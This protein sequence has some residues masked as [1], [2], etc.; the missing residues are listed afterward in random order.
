MKVLGISGSLIYADNH[1]ASAALVIDGKLVGNYE[2]ERF[3]RIKHSV[4]KSFPINCIQRLLQENNLTID[5]ID[6]ISMPHDP[7]YKER[8]IKDIVNRI[9]ANSTHVPELIYEDHHMAHACDSFFQ[10]GFE[11]A[12][13]VIIDGSGDNKD[14][15]TITHIK[16]NKIKVLKKYPYTKSLG[17]LYSTGATGYTNLGEFGEGKFMGLASYGQP[18]DT[19]PFR[20]ENNDI[21]LDIAYDETAYNLYNVIDAGLV[22]YFKKNSYP[23]AMSTCDNDAM[24]YANFASSIQKTFNDIVMELVRYAKELSGEDNLVLSGGCIQNCIAN[25]L[26][27]ESGLFKNVFAGPAPH[28]AGCAAGLAFHASYVM[29]EKINNKRLTNSYVGKTYS[30]DE[31]LKVCEGYN[32]EEYNEDKVASIIKGNSIIGWF[33]GGSE[34]GPRALGH[35]SIIANPAT[36]NNLNLINNTVKHRENWRPLAPTVPNELFDKIFKTNSKDLTE[37]MLRTLTIRP[38]LRKK[39]TAVCHIDNTT[40]PQCLQRDVNPELYDLIMKFYKISGVPCVI[41][42]S[43][44]GKGEPIVETPQEAINFLERTPNMDYIIFNAKYIVKRKGS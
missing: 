19:I 16:D 2:E 40:R 9:C 24:Y 32:V 7:R 4:G 41:N 17:L 6:V 8:D 37:F 31:I 39:L 42:T 5:D 21:V 33:Q 29:G 23:Y 38:E 26:I 28:D 3:N 27:V 11:S 10:S 34:I 14:G 35:R 22:S 25:N 15:I 44:N 43:F 1:D 30:D 12:V 20:W 13:C 18:V 36:R